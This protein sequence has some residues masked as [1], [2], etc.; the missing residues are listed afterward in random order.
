MDTRR[1]SRKHSI[2]TRKGEGKENAPA[3]GVP[4]NENKHAESSTTIDSMDVMWSFIH[5]IQRATRRKAV[6]QQALLPKNT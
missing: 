5:K 3:G 6:W 1:P 2:D 4:P